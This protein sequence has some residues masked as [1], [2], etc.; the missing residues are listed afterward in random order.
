MVVPNQDD[1]LEA[2]S[3]LPL[4]QQFVRLQKQI[5]L[6]PA[7]ERLLDRLV[8]S[9][10]DK[11]VAVFFHLRPTDGGRCDLKQ[12]VAQ[13]TLLENIR[14]FLKQIADRQDLHQLTVPGLQD[15]LL[16]PSFRMGSEECHNFGTMALERCVLAPGQQN[17]S[18]FLNC[19]LV[20]RV[21]FQQ[22]APF[23]QE[24]LPLPFPESTCPFVSVPSE[25]PWTQDVLGPALVSCSLQPEAKHVCQ[26]LF[27][28]VRL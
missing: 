17:L 27:G 1:F 16:L 11:L 20:S 21:V 24:G 28:S 2:A 5:V 15:L 22:L 13:Q 12:A 3:S 8:I 6:P 18:H 26:G 9:C 14:C 19:M 23:D 10:S 7:M 4:L 25:Q